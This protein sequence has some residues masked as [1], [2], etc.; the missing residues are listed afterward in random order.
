MRIIVHEPTGNRNSD[1]KSLLY[2]TEYM[3]EGR[4]ATRTLILHGQAFKNSLM[5]LKNEGRE[6]VTLLSAV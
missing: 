2:V 1:I 3:I 5:Y 6:G 4:F